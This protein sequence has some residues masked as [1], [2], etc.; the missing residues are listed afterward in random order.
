MLF[1]PDPASLMH[2]IG[3]TL[4]LAHGGGDP[5]NCK[6][7]YVSVM[8]YVLGLGIPQN[9]VPMG[10]VGQ[11]QLVRPGLGPMIVDFSPPRTQSA[12]GAAIT[13]GAAPLGP[14]TE[15]NLLESTVQDASDT[16]N[17]F[18]FVDG[19]GAQQ[20]YPLN[21]PMAGFNVCGMPAPAGYF[22]DWDGSC[23]VTGMPVTADIDSS[24]VCPQN[25]G[26]GLEDLQTQNS[27]ANMMDE[28]GDG[29]QDAADPDCTFVGFDDWTN[30]QI[31]IS[32]GAVSPL[33]RPHD[34]DPRIEEL[35]AFY[36]QSQAPTPPAGT[37]L[38]VELRLRDQSLHRRYW[39]HA[40]QAIGVDVVVTNLG[41]LAAAEVQVRV[42]L[43]GGYALLRVPTV[44]TVAGPSVISCDLGAMAPAEQKTVALSLRPLGND[45]DRALRATVEAIGLADPV[46]AN[47]VSELVVNAP[48]RCR[49]LRAQPS[50]LWPADGRLVP[51]KLVGATDPDGD[52]LDVNIVAVR[53]DE[54]VGLLPDAVI[55]APGSGKVK[56]RAERSAFGGGRVYHI[57]AEVTDA[58]GASCSGKVRLCV[59][60][61]RFPLAP[62][63]RH[64]PGC[65]DQGPRFDSTSP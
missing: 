10:V 26:I 16:L 33:S 20:F 23:A 3:H 4:G 21:A 7:N 17:Q 13:R 50:A 34:R 38:S 55:G 62:H 49:A 30:I 60:A 14:L 37:D 24:T 22:I 6:P 44:C 42:D 9:P 53:Q 46:P 39:R 1:N 29:K 63:A 40:R 31:G 5:H 56:L 47:N 48:P 32:R 36:H 2:E 58:L 15:T 45:D 43:P 25:L 18:V 57:E 54:R 64:A 51:V 19:M 41:P 65:V 8:N 52:D 27:C 61:P 12:L 28:D 59:P 11:G 35:E